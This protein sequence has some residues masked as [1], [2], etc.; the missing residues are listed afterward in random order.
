MDRSRTGCRKQGFTLIELL[1][2]IGIIAL[3][4]AI[5]IPTLNGAFGSAKKARAMQQCKDL[6]GACQN[7]FAQY[8][9]MPV[10]Q[11]TKH[12]AGDKGYAQ[13]NKDVVDILILADGLKNR[14]VVNS[15]GI[16]FLDMDAKTLENYGK[17]GEFRDPW[18][19]PYEIYLDMDFD[20][21]IDASGLDEI[22]AKVAVRSLGPD[23]KK[24]TPDDIRT[25]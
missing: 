8:N 25:W 18:D 14:E 22:R 11:G 6:Q 20:D 10:P 21:R 23:G 4:A 5:I 17:S 15:K 24:D 9:R 12:G 7:Y 13:D 3:L 2:V 1:V 19:N 16:R